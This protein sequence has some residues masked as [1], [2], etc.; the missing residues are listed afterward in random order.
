MWIMIRY[1]I[2]TIFPLKNEGEKRA[3]LASGQPKDQQSTFGGEDKAASDE[4][5]DCI[6]QVY[7]NL[8]DFYCDTGCGGSYSPLTLTSRPQIR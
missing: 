8:G 4:H 7:E 3:R 5:D 2:A 1:C 6:L